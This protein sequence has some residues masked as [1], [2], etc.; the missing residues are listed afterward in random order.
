MKNNEQKI[1]KYR[2]L[3]RSVDKIVILERKKAIDKLRESGH[4]DPIFLVLGHDKLLSSKGLKADRVLKKIYKS[5][6]K[7]DLSGR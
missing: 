6:K 5:I 2:A 3:I 4:S 7:I 1:Q